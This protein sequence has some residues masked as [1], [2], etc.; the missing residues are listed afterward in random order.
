MQRLGIDRLKAFPNVLILTTS[1]LSEFKPIWCFMLGVASWLFVICISTGQS[2]LRLSIELIWSN[3]LVFQWSEPDIPFCHRVSRS[4]SE[5][6]WLLPQDGM[7]MM[8]NS[9]TTLWSIVMFEHYAVTCIV[10]GRSL[11]IQCLPFHL[12]R[13]HFKQKRRNHRNKSLIQS[14]SVPK[15]CS[16][17]QEIWRD[18]LEDLCWVFYDDAIHSFSL[19]VDWSAYLSWLTIDGEGGNFRSR[20]YSMAFK[21]HRVHWST[22][23]ERW[24]NK[25]S[26]KENKEEN[27]KERRIIRGNRSIGFCLL[28]WVGV[29]T[30]SVGVSP[31]KSCI[32]TN[33]RIYERQRA[34]EHH[35]DLD[36]SV[37]HDFMLR[38]EV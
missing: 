37:F 33:C 4:C 32:F 29:A 21:G 6:D 10:M 18:F 11:G 13:V 23:W 36:W 16:K 8:R 26:L 3:I 2:T 1:N 24:G 27:C 15:C 17:S 31:F 9:T 34:D 14:R 30:W 28:W 22:F 20:R 5:R 25:Y 38:L 7:A 12:H 19:F 35:R